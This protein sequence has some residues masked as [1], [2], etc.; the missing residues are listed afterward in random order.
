[1]YQMSN[2][3]VVDVLNWCVCVHEARNAVCVCECPTG[4][5]GLVTAF[6][7]SAFDS[8]APLVPSNQVFNSAYVVHG[9]HRCTAGVGRV[10]S[11]LTFAC[12]LTEFHWFWY[13]FYHLVEARGIAVLCWQF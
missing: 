8:A 4:V 9:G 3:F 13:N 1:M 10:I 6:C 7:G 5:D 2:T 12:F 11:L